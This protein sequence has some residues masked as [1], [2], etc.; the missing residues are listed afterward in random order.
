MKRRDFITLLGGAAVGWPLAARAQQANATIGL[1]SAGSPEGEASFITAFRQGL[2]ETGHFEGRN[3]AIEY[4][5]AHNDAAL[6]SAHAMDLVRRK[7]NVI[8]VPSG[9]P[10]VLAAKAATGTIPIVF[11]TGADPIR[12]GL[13]ASLSRP[14][15]NLTGVSALSSELNT[16]RL[17]LLNELLLSGGEITAL[18]DP[19]SPDGQLATAELRTASTQ[20]GRS[21][22]VLN[23]GTPREIDRAFEIASQNRSE[24]L[25]IGNSVFFTNRAA[26]IVILAARYRLPA[27]YPLRDFTQIGGL[28]SYGGSVTEQLRQVGVYAGRILDGEK[29]ADLP[30]VQSAKFEFVVNLNTARA[31]G[32][33]VPATLVARAD[34]VIE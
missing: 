23:A 11:R 10:A 9:T 20:I 13:V 5:W 18:I 3:V 17:G 25:L 19:N 16:K 24:A 4:R 27:I 33:E 1:L 14:G 6:L 34:E 31:I 2:T 21:V 30:V 32:I 7:V 26:Q 29:P 8:V 28:M 12:S 22:G 15:G